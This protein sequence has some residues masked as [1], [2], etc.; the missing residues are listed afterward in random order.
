MLHELHT[1]DPF[2]DVRPDEH[3]VHAAAPALDNV[4]ISHGEQDSLFVEP[5]IVLL[6]PGG[7]GTQV[8]IDDAPVAVEYVPWLH[9]LQLYDDE[10]PNVSLHVPAPQE[11][12]IP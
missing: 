1:A 7:Q 6:D 10:L 8:D 5:F 3:C 4:P 2:G 12:Q 11:L 9:V